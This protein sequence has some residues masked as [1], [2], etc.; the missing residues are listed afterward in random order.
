M[1]HRNRCGSDSCENHSVRSFLCLRGSESLR[2][3]KASRARGCEWLRHWGSAA[4]CLPR[5]SLFFLPL[6][7]SFVSRLGPVRLDSALLGPR[8]SLLSVLPRPAPSPPFS[9]LGRSP[10][11]VVPLPRALP[12]VPLR[13]P[14]FHTL[15]LA[16]P[17]G[18]QPL[19]FTSG[20]LGGGF[21]KTTSKLK[22]PPASLLNSSRTRTLGGQRRLSSAGNER[23]R[24][25]VRDPHELQ[26]RDERSQKRGSVDEST[27]TYRRICQN[28]SPVFRR[29][30]F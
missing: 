25:E 8:T 26:H 14:L 13:V 27:H 11:D 4:L 23:G 21:D 24:G 28:K 9:L 6:L 12:P 19:V 7:V 15:P 2:T 16:G 17:H 10:A 30:T 22:H 20:Q 1:G 5:V 29:V 18:Y 3:T